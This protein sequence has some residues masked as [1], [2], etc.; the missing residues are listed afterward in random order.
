MVFAVHWHQSAMGL[1]VFPILIPAST[2]LPIPSLWVFPVHQPWALVS[3]IHPGLIQ[4]ITWAG[5]LF[6][7]WE[8]TCFNAILSEHPTLAFSHRVQK[9]VLY[10]CVYIFFCFAYS[11][12]S[13]PS[14]KIPY[15][16]ISILY[17]SL[18]F[19]LTSLCI[20]GSSFIHLIKT[21]SN[22]LL[23][24][25]VP[26]FIMIFIC[27]HCILRWIIMQALFVVVSNWYSGQNIKRRLWGNKPRFWEKWLIRHFLTKGTSE[28]YSSR[29]ICIDQKWWN[30]SEFIRQQGYWSDY[31]LFYVLCLLHSWQ[32]SDFSD[33]KMNI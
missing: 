5:D 26:F 13:L 6:H 25:F 29:K 7:P 15:I 4:Q 19:W 16:C 32:C 3:C 30:G 10:I 12:I 20:M 17:W 31:I 8:Y 33:W 23:L 22:E 14:F 28:I 24:F 2:S 21:G 11:V 27:S 1:H 18:S 9:S